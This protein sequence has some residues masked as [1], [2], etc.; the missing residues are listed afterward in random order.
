VTDETIGL[1]LR[2]ADECG[3]VERID[4]MFSGRD[5]NVTEQRAAFHV[6][7][8]APKNERIVVDGADV[9]PEARGPRSHDGPLRRGP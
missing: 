4:A 3:I 8:R 2:F 1:L 5:I 9:V 6:T 7:V